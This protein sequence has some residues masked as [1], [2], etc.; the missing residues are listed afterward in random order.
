VREVQ[1]LVAENGVLYLILPLLSDPFFIFFRRFIQSG[2]VNE[3]PTL[4]PVLFNPDLR[5]QGGMSRIRRRPPFA[6]GSTI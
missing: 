3:T 6:T 4:L 1:D 5:V 2:R